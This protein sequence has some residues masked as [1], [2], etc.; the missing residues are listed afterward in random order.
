MIWTC[1]DYQLDFVAFVA[2][3]LV[4]LF[5][6]GRL[7]ER[8]QREHTAY[9]VSEVMTAVFLVAGN[10]YVHKVDATQRCNLINHMS[11][12]ATTYAGETEKLNHANLSDNVSSDDPDYRK[13]VDAQRRW[14]QANALVSDIY[15]IRRTA[16]GGTILVVDSETDYDHSGAIDQDR[17]QR[18]DP[19]EPYEGFSSG[20]QAQAIQ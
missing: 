20:E 3:C 6:L 17:E 12:F 4:G 14:L 16:E 8:C 9:L 19:G 15:T 2:C 5:V 18:T 1:I 7:V 10:R 13:V 11:A